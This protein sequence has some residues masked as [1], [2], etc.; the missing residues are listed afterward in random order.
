MVTTRRHLAP[1]PLAVRLVQVG[2]AIALLVVAPLLPG[3]SSAQAGASD[4]GRLVV[5]VT[6]TRVAAEG[7]CVVLRD[8][9]VGMA[10]GAYCDNDDADRD[11]RTGRLDLDLPRRS[12]AIGA[13][14]PG[15]DVLQVTPARFVL[16][17]RQT[18][19]VR[20]GRSGT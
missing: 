3:G 11:G 19:V 14:T 1:P 6:G 2:L 8:L 17:A 4:R 15:R 9:T 16:G 18:V 13:R 12:F 5:V 7:T 10:V 20:L